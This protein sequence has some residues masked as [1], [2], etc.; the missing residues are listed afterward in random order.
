MTLQEFFD[1][2]SYNP[3]W[4]LAYFALVPLAAVAV[5]RMSG[6][7]GLQKPWDVTYSVL[8][9]M[10]AIPGLL[11]VA[12][13]IYLFLFERRSIMQTNLITQLVPIVSFIATLLIIRKNVPV[14]AIP[15]FG[16]ISSLIV[17][18]FGAFAIMWA[19]DRTRIFF[20]AFSFMPIQYVLA[21]F[22]GLLVIIRIGWKRFFR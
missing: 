9:F 11:A 16:K 7:R 6:K 18:I 3:I 20:V 10:V 21:I 5:N 22:I 4:V 2:L 8:V 12:F 1:F 14:E 19:L 13:N 15:G 17:M